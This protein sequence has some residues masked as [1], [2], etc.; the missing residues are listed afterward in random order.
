MAGILIGTSGHA[1]RKE[2][3]VENPTIVRRIQK[4]GDYYGA[5]YCIT[6]TLMNPAVNGLRAAILF[7]EVSLNSIFSS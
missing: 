1:L 4:L 5:A 6:R 2:P 3:V 7:T